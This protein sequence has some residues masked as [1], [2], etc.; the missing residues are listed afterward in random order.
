M[1]TQEIQILIK[2]FND[3]AE[4]PVLDDKSIEEGQG[5]VASSKF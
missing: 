3:L 4:L 2:H 1:K 5:S